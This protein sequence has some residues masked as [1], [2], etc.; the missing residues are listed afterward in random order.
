MVFERHKRLLAFLDALGGN[1]GNLDFQKL[2]F[3]YCSEREDKPMYEFIPYKF[4]GF[5][6][7]SY[8]DRRRLI[9]HGLLENEEQTWALTAEGRKTAAV[10]PA[11]RM[12]MD[13]FAKDHTHLRGE[14]LVAEVYRRYPY[15]AIRSKMAERILAGDDLALLAIESSKPPAGKPG[16]ATIGY[17]GRSLESYLNKLLKNGVSLLCDVRKNAFSHKYGF[18]KRPLQR[19]CEAVGIRYEHLPELGIASDKRQELNTQ[20]DYDA[21]FD[22]YEREILPQRAG[23]LER[24]RDWMTS[25]ERVALTCFELSP[26]Q[27]HR[28]CVA[29]EMHRRWG[30]ALK[31]EH[32]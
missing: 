28:H 2:L 1:L 22:I 12:R 31:A 3:L 16:L 18:S 32:L 29:D 8:D 30:D 6:F 26:H 27:C 4:G 25:G 13:K 14:G 19:G 7:T 21:L 23:A 24:I 20:A 5:S 11:M 9:E 15:F 10:A 17:E